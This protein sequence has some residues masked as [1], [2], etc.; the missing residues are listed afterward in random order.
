[1]SKTNNSTSTLR[2]RDYTF[3]KETIL[4]LDA[5]RRL[6]EAYDAIYAATDAAFADV[7]TVMDEKILPQ[8]IALQD[9]TRDLLGDRIIDSLAK[10][11]LTGKAAIAI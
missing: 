2:N 3:S 7:D 9:A 8:Y 5:L 11:K 4:Y 1:M 10:S 6:N